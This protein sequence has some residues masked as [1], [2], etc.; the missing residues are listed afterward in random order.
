MRALAPVL[1]NAYPGGD[2]WLSQRL[3][4][5]ED[6]RASARL[7]DAGS[8]L[9]AVAIETPK[10][11]GQVKLSTLWVEPDLRG[12]GLGHELLRHCTARW[13]AAGICKAW[14]TANP[15]AVNAV[16]ALVV[17]HGFALTARERD[18]YGPGRDEWVF[19][20]TSNR[21][22]SAGRTPPELAIS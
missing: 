14:I 13:A 1:A 22:V 18:R 4:D 20:W 8:V 16:G 5:I 17:R 3:D 10:L 11:P 9:A 19:H 21:S 2:Q 12:R 7:I 6:G 15:D